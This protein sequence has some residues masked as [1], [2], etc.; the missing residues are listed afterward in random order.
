MKNCIRCFKTI[1]E[2]E[3]DGIIQYNAIEIPK[4][5]NLGLDEGMLCDCCQGTLTVVQGSGIKAHGFLTAHPR[6]SCE[7]CGHSWEAESAKLPG[8]C[9]NKKCR[10]YLWNRPRQVKG[11]KDIASV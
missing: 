6:L 7:R 9:P 4:F 1:Q 5:N 3:V 11:S 8:T 10:S 2:K